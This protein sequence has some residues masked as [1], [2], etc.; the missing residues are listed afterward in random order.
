M[1]NLLF[2]LFALGLLVTGSLVA[3]LPSCGRS[4]WAYTLQG[5]LLALY[6]ALA[7]ALGGTPALYGWA[8]TILISKGLILP[9][10]FQRA[11][12]AIPMGSSGALP[13][14]RLAAAFLIGLAAFGAGASLL[15]PLLSGI[16]GV[17]STVPYGLGAGCGVM[18]VA[19]WTILTHGH[20]FKAALGLGLLENGAHLCLAAVA[21]TLPEIASI[22]VVIDVILAVW[23]LL[24]AGRE[25][26]R[27]HDPIQ[28]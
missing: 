1:A 21:W 26:E 5:W 2:P 18:A 7:G 6:L 17:A 13:K 9:L 8:V 20:F 23:I 15:P 10:I 11:G 27:V 28:G 24:W 14:N 25:A 4:T 12:R 3:E 19:L 22:G 16:P